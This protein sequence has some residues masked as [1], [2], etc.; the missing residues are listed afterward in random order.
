MNYTV[1]ENLCIEIFFN[2]APAP[3]IRQPHQPTG[4]PWAD[5]AEASAWAE[6]YIYKYENPP[7]VE[8]APVV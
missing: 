4:A 1:D 6:D 2:G 3:L 5:S 7:V 8:E